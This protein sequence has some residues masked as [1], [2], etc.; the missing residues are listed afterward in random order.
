MIEPYCSR[1]R[2]RSL[3]ITTSSI[4]SGSHPSGQSATAAST[5]WS[6]S[7]SCIASRKP[8]RRAT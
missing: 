2:M 5:N 6:R 4:L 8:P 1:T 7:L 3:A